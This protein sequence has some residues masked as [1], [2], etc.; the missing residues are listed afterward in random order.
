MIELITFD[1]DDT[2]WDNEPVIRRAIHKGYSWLLQ[3]HPELAKIHDVTSLDTLKEAIRT[4]TPALEYR[5]S[6]V[7][8]V[9]MTQALQDIGCDAATARQLA[10]EAFDYFNIWRHKIELFAGAKEMLATLAM[11]YRLAVITNGNVDI[12]RIGLGDYFA[13]SVSADTLNCAKPSPD[14]FE[15]A[16][17]RANVAPEKTLHIGDNLITDIYGA[18]NLGMKTLWFNPKN[19]PL[20]EDITVPDITVH[21]LADIPAAID[22]FL[23]NPPNC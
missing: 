4:S 19:R 20:P 11:K 6:E 16:L 3:R 21:M 5:V 10:E 22:A 7:R 9:G 23:N 17:R 14:I 1:L 12:R 18:A 2:L 15:Y 8:I 13:F